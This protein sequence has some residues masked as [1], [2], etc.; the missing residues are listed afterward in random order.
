M[1]VRPLPFHPS[2]GATAVQPTCSC[3]AAGRRRDLGVRVE[4]LDEVRVNVFKRITVWWLNV[5]VIFCNWVLH[6]STTI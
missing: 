2:I 1:G 3:E 6:V 4:L 5:E